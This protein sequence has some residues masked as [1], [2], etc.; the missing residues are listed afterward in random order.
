MSFFR[1]RN[2]DLAMMMDEPDQAADINEIRRVTCDSS[3][4]YGRFWKQ[5]LIRLNKII[6]TFLEK[7]PFM[8][9][10]CVLGPVGT[11]RAHLCDLSREITRYINDLKSSPHHL[12]C[13]QDL[14]GKHTP[15]KYVNECIRQIVDI[16]GDYVAEWM[17]AATAFG[18]STNKEGEAVVVWH[19]SRH[20]WN[21]IW[22][23]SGFIPVE[24][25]G[26]PPFQVEL[27]EF[28]HQA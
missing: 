5:V 19:N 20:L 9:P 10:P 14:N 22:R 26:L 24:T 13:F 4:R 1:I 3:G 6:I 2:M 16:A 18:T 17:K 23:T 15:V 7:F 11:P 12:E 28:Q 21:H 27:E 8:F 25:M